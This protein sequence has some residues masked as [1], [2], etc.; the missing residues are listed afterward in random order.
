[1]SA[2]GVIPAQAGVAPALRFPRANRGSTIKRDS[3]LR[4]NDGTK[5]P[6]Q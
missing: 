6:R 3:R 4:G 5:D 1:M 2:F